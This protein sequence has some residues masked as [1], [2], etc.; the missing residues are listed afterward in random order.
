MRVGNRERYTDSCIS[1]QFFQ[2]IAT[3]CSQIQDP[4]FN[5]AVSG[6]RHLFDE[7]RKAHPNCSYIRF[8]LASR[9]ADIN[10]VDWKGNSF[11][12]AYWH[13]DGGLGK[14]NYWWNILHPFWSKVDLEAKLAAFKAHFY[15]L[16]DIL[17]DYGFDIMNGNGFRR[18]PAGERSHQILAG[19]RFLD[20]AE[21]EIMARH[22]VPRLIQFFERLYFSRGYS[23]DDMSAIGTIS[24]LSP[25]LWSVPESYKPEV[26]LY[27]IMKGARWNNP[28]WKQPGYEAR[29]TNF[30]EQVPPAAAARMIVD[31][32]EQLGGDY[33]KKAVGANLRGFLVAAYGPVGAVAILEKAAGLVGFQRRDRILIAAPVH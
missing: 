32:Q 14:H 6:N 9:Q 7:L 27:F 28:V 2:A 8:L 25:L 4:L 29:I 33:V 19:F 26:I 15:P 5:M 12:T 24:Y 13:I 23:V 1:P 18:G 30:A 3:Q 22:D 17:E 10:A 16:L 20:R 21:F 31:L 11:V